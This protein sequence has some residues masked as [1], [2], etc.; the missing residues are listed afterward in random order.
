MSIRWRL[1][2]TFSVC[3]AFACGAIAVIVYN[4]AAESD[5]R[6]FD[7]LAISQ[8]EQIDNYIATYLEP[9]KTNVRYLADLYIVRN[10]RGKLESFLERDS[11]TQL[12]YAEF[13]EYY[14]RVYDELIRVQRSNDNY[15]QVFIANNDGQFAL[16]PD[17]LTLPGGY[18]PRT[19]P[20]YIETNND[21]N[22]ITITSP[23]LDIAGS[24]EWVCGVVTKI[25]DLENKPLGQ[26]SVEYNL[27]K[28]INDLNSRRILETGHLVVYDKHGINFVNGKTP[29]MPK[30]SPEDYPALL[31][32]IAGTDI[33][34]FDDIGDDGHSLHVVE[35]TMQS[36][37]WKIA[38][39]FE[40]SELE[41]GSMS[42]LFTV[43]I[44][45]LA[46][47]VA[48][49]VFVNFIAGGIVRPIEQLIEAS[50]II[51]AGD[52][53]INAEVRKTLD[54]KL[55]VTGSGESR[56]LS[57]SLKIML[58]TLQD[59]VEKA[60][61]ADNAKSD[62]LA[63]M[64]HEIRTPM[65]AI[66]GM[67]E[68][69]LSE[70]TSPDVEEYIREI[71]SAGANLLSV[72]NNILDFSKIESGKLEVT[73]SPYFFS[74]LINDVVNLIRVQIAEK[75]IIFVANIDSNIPNRLF[76]DEVRV[77]QILTNLLSNA[78]KYTKEGCITLTVTA[79]IVSER[80]ARFKF[81]VADTGI[82]I[83]KEDMTLLFEK[84]SRID[85]SVSNT[86]VGTG[87]GLSIAQSLCRMMN[88]EVTAL[89]EYMSG[90]V[91]TAV[92]DQEYTNYEK[93]A[94]V[95]DAEQKRVLFF[96]R[97]PQVADS[98][99]Y[100]FASLGVAA[101]RAADAVN[102]FEELTTG[103]YNFAFFS[104]G[105]IKQAMNLA[106]TMNIK[107]ILV[108]LLSVGET[109]K[110]NIGN[111]TMPA[112]ALP[113]A[114]TLNQTAAM[115]LQ[116][117]NS[118]RFLAPLAHILVVDDLAVNIKVTQGLLAPYKMRVSACLSGEE[119]LELIRGHKYDLIF[120]DHMM[121]GMNGIETTQAIRAMDS[122]YCKTV[123]IVALTA[124]AVAGMKE[125]F[126]EKGFND[127]LAK[128]V[129]ISKLASILEHWIV[130]EKR[131]KSGETAEV[132]PDVRTLPDIY[133]ID[134]ERGIS[135]AGGSETNY[136]EILR[137]FSEDAHKR[138]AELRKITIRE[139]EDYSQLA[140][141]THALKGSSGF[142]G[143]QTFTELSA[144]L[145]VVI[146]TGENVIIHRKLKNYIEELKKITDSIDT[147]IESIEEIAAENAANGSS[148]SSGDLLTL[149]QALGADDIFSVDK[150]LAALGETSLDANSRAVLDEIGNY[151]L[152]SDIKSAI[153]VL[154]TLIAEKSN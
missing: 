136:I 141:D 20:W 93:F 129:E 67:S 32:R 76:G 56:V 126:L 69:A 109:H 17:G 117:N 122:E 116:N 31:R 39:I 51:S 62:F 101:V 147:V 60:V 35:H 7:N 15:N 65:N 83:R 19:R 154:D 37:G 28:L 96:E 63:N 43:M 89:S 73:N 95:Q 3:L 55:S 107:T 26:L 138:L 113:I 61:K 49:L 57:D 6:A 29:T 8:L 149:R 81:E 18:D 124:N 25:Y 16:T 151:L 77:R 134:V 70:N 142:I 115:R 94:A 127:F 99:E 120:M 80:F 111:I 135:L 100:T 123:P 48:A 53:E 110:Y 144:E 50:K 1:I 82:G 38:V 92:L 86:V 52:Y 24:G 130:K 27:G 84:F 74:S 148:I 78:A 30:R 46:S 75:P 118:V 146:K 64:S 58:T 145:G 47:F 41:S 10:S 68:L 119:A 45:A 21:L 104:S 108:A 143:A 139:G 97:F 131:L 133:G 153:S 54:K 106:E 112:Y 132:T 140:A 152:V 44:A 85:K 72:V 103:V 14:Q 12:R 2:L 23:Y 150:L 125:M 5:E 34:K 22:D 90:S 98:L 105:Q 11:D 42:L 91:F 36:T 88:G 114:N 137:L 9:G 59:R 121:P 71:K 66:I 79:E 128:P 40:K 33:D 87:L 4:K 102:F 13:S